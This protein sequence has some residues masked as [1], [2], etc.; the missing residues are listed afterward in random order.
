M[1]YVYPFELGPPP[2]Q[3][4]IEFPEINVIYMTDLP[5]IKF[6]D[7]AERHSLLV[8]DDLWTESVS[9]PDI[10]KAFKVKY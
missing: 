3:W 10:V 4:D 8:L 5:S 9:N 7:N 2:V 6:F 1:Y